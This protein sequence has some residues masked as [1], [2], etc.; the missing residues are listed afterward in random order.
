MCLWHTLQPLPLLLCA[1]PH[2]TTSFTLSWCRSNPRSNL[3]HIVT[4]LSSIVCRGLPPCNPSF[5]YIYVSSSLPS[6]L[7]ARL[8]SSPP[9]FPALTPPPPGFP[10]PPALL[11]AISLPAS[12]LS[13]LTVLWQII[14]LQRGLTSSQHA[15]SA[16][17]YHPSYLFI[18]LSIY[19]S[20]YL[21][22]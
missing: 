13:S 17:L 7:N 5:F 1:V 6:L 16:G 3:S 11:P 19:V 22:I 12:F 14:I 15:V 18:Y 9:L 21:F 2:S 8:P 20:I 4:S 10:P